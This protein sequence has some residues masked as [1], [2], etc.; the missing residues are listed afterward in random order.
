MTPPEGL[1]HF[2]LMSLPH[3]GGEC[4]GRSTDR[5]Q[6]LRRD[7]DLAHGGDDSVDRSAVDDAGESVAQISSLH[8]VDYVDRQAGSVRVSRFGIDQ[9][10]VKPPQRAR[11]Q[12]GTLTCGIR[13]KF[14]QPATNSIARC[15]LFQ[16]GTG[17]S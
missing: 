7:D 16:S 4:D 14:S 12:Y 9:C 17:A 6:P 2:R 1:Q 15:I 5:Q 10:H 3:L 8:L 11:G 13:L